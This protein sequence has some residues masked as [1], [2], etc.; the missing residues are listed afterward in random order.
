MKCM[1]MY[2]HVHIQNF[3]SFSN[4]YTTLCNFDVSS[5]HRNT[6]MSY[7]LAKNWWIRV[8]RNLVPVCIGCRCLVARYVNMLRVAWIAAAA[9]SERLSW[10]LKRSSETSRLRFIIDVTSSRYFLAKLASTPIIVIHQLTKNCRKH[11]HAWTRRHETRSCRK[12]FNLQS[13]R[14]P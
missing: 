9:T 6:I 3:P 1:Y 13:K 5:C 4:V 11:T 10:R 2:M 7:Y 12:R 14:S 8:S